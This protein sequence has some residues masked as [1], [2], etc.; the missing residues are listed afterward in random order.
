MIIGMNIIVFTFYYQPKNLIGVTNASITVF[1]VIFLFALRAKRIIA[2]ILLIPLG[3]LYLYLIIIQKTSMQ[4]LAL[5][6]NY[7]LFAIAIIIM[8][9]VFEKT[10]FN[11]FKMRR[12]AILN[13]KIG[14]LAKREA[15][16]SKKKAIN[17]ET[18]NRQK[19]EFLAIMGHELRTPLNSIIGYTRI[20]LNDEKNQDKINQ[21]NIINSQG[22][23]LVKIINDILDISRIESGK[24]NIVNK[25]FNLES[26]IDGIL[27]SINI[28]LKNRNNKII[29]KKS[30]NLSKYIIT[31]PL[32]LEQILINLLS[33]AIKFTENGIIIFEIIEDKNIIHNKKK[34]IFKVSDNGIGIDKKKLKFIFKK[35]AQVHDSR[36]RRYK[37]TGLGLFIVKKLV[38]LL[39][40]KINVESKKGEG[41]IFTVEFNFKIPKQEQIEKTIAKPIIQKNINQDLGK[42]KIILA[43]DNKNNQELVKKM[44]E[45][46]NSSVFIANNG[47]EVLKLLEK[48]KY[49]LIL[50][51]IEMPELDGLETTARIRESKREYK[52]IPI[53]ALT[54]YASEKDRTNCLKIGINDFIAKP[55]QFENFYEKINKFKK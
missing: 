39:N 31:D 19:S 55:I 9:T 27:A 50:M 52:N 51:D 53:I 43:E 15:M 22:E 1:L 46:K 42:M 48:E 3:V 14:D 47:L 11:E 26:L 4:D 25:I 35:F 21:L 54:A 13:K 10:A 17:A 2:F 6:S 23:S 12:M 38:G 5:L 45:I 32:R 37:G 34:F 30:D 18:E 24:I 28:D 8:S 33:N 44:L 16:N 49:D 36:I 41:S 7:L 40:G 20:L 29:I